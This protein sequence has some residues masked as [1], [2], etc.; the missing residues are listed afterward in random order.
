LRLIHS[1]AASVAL[2]EIPAPPFDFNNQQ[3]MPM[4]GTLADGFMGGLL[5]AARGLSSPLFLGVKRRRAK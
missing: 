4:G 2:P 5:V 1:I 3:Q